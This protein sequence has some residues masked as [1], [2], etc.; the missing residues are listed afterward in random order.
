MQK[1]QI[2]PAVQKLQMSMTEWRLRLEGC[3]AAAAA[4]AAVAAAGA[5]G[6][7]AA[8]AAST[9]AAAAAAGDGVRRQTRATG[10]WESL[11]MYVNY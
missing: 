4:A 8:G 3:A 7:G 11:C 1:L 9:A 5:A 2:S 10:R 6:A